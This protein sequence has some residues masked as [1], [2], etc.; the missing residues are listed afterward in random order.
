[1][2]N[3]KNFVTFNSDP[4]IVYSVCVGVP[5]LKVHITKNRSLASFPNNF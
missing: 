2:L 3:L 5:S 1:L 4:L